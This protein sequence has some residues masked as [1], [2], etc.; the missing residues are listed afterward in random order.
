MISHS[1]LPYN[2]DTIDVSKEFSLE[3]PQNMSKI[4]KSF[5]TTS[6]LEASN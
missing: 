5:R 6:S 3:V 2:E 4:K 1:N